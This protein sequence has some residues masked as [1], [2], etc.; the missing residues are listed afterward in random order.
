MKYNL[1]KMSGLQH[2][3]WAKKIP[4]LW[5]EMSKMTE[6]HLPGSLQEPHQKSTTSETQEKLRAECVVHDTQQGSDTLG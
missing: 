3:T 1:E 6:Q 2:S 5:E 4:S